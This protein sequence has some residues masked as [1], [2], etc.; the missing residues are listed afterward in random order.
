MLLILFKFY[1]LICV[2][3]FQVISNLIARGVCV[4]VCV[5]VREREQE[6][7]R[8]CICV[9]YFFLTLLSKISKTLP[10]FSLHV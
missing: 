4:C 8:I 10:F 1:F 3:I 7:E 2:F 6:R 9:I 5:C